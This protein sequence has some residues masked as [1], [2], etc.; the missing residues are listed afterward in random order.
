MWTQ[1]TGWLYSLP[2]SLLFYVDF[3]ALEETHEIQQKIRNLAKVHWPK[4]NK[5]TPCLPSIVLRLDKPGKSAWQRRLYF[6]VWKYYPFVSCW[7]FVLPSL[8]VRVCVCVS[9]C[10]YMCVRSAQGMCL[11]G[12]WLLSLAPDLGSAFL[13][14][15][16][17]LLQEGKRWREW[18]RE[19]QT[20]GE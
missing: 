4:I 11:K 6:S 2:Y 8:C 17:Q 9:V 16:P 1:L 3:P 7:L 5:R 13:I 14:S 12:V 19:R 15:L 18:E 20:E 10:V